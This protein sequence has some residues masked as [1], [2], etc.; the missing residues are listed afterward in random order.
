M[1]SRLAKECPERHILKH[2]HGKKVTGSLLHRGDPHL[3]NAVG[4]GTGD[5]LA[6]ES[7]RAPCWYF[8]TDDQIEQSAF[9][10]TVWADDGENFAIVG[11]HGHAVESS[12]AAKVFHD[13]IQ[14]E[15][16]H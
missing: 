7:D 13:L 12:E 14:F 9:S 3:T 1:C 2:S 10:G 8:E 11:L 16:C 5:V 15:Y 6:G 4:G